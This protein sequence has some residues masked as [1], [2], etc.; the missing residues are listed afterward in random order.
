MGYVHKT[1]PLFFL[2]ALLRFVVRLGVI[3]GRV[4]LH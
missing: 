1:Q 4:D 3:R 2:D